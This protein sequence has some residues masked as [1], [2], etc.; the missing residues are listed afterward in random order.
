MLQLQAQAPR[1]ATMLMD[2]QSMA[3]PPTLQE[4]HWSLAGIQHIHLHT[5]CPSSPTI[6]LDTL[7]EHVTWTMPMVT[8]LHLVM[9]MSWFQPTIM[10]PTIMQEKSRD[11]FVDLLHK[12]IWAIYNITCFCLTRPISYV[13]LPF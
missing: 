13:Y 11:T 10:H 4:L 3:M 6:Q 12:F 2:I 8:P 7:Q 5:W 9:V 1:L